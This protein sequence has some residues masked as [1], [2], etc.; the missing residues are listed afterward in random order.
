MTS[1]SSW[2]VRWRRPPDAHE[3]QGPLDVS[4]LGRIAGWQGLLGEIQRDGGLVQ[5]I[6]LFP[7]RCLADVRQH[8]SQRRT[9][10]S[11]LLLMVIGELLNRSLNAHDLVLWG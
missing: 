6:H 2:R 4:N 5:A 11:G 7:R 1:V 3:T 10:G 8:S 9:G